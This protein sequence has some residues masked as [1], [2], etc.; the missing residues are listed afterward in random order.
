MATGFDVS[1]KPRW[2]QL[3]RKGRSL[4]DEWKDEPASYFSLAANGQP[5]Y[6]I[7]MGPAGPVGHGSLTSAIDWTADYVLKWLVKM[8]KEDIKSF[9]VKAQVQDD[10]NVWGEELMKRTV[11]SSGCR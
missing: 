9:E 6:F 8:A 2:Q 1:F 4:A 3:G 10:W 7:F 11:W 5:N